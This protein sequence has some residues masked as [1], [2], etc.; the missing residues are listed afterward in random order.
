MTLA[1]LVGFDLCPRLAGL[2]S[3]KLYLPRGLKVPASLQPVVREV[4]STRA[5]SRGWDPLLRIAASTK[6][7][8]CSAT[9][10]LDRF[11][12]AARGDVAF[13]RSPQP[14]FRKQR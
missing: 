11:G 1:K 8:W 7:G 12:S 10:I 2:G 9:Y 6:T 5:I 13:Q 14:L 4:V 3:R